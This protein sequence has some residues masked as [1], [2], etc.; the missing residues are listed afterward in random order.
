MAAALLRKDK[1]EGR[2][3]WIFTM[4][5]PWRANVTAFPLGKAASF[6]LVVQSSDANKHACASHPE[7]LI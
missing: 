7:S 4:F 3:M 2:W 1:K 5:S 6:A